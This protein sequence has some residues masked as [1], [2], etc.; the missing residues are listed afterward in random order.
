MIHFSLQKTKRTLLTRV[1]LFGL[2]F[3]HDDNNE[4]FRGLKSMEG[5]QRQNEKSERTLRE[6]E[7]QR[8]KERER[9]KEGERERERRER[10][11]NKSNDEVAAMVETAAGKCE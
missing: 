9:E 4:R 8:P 11:G 10:G 5:R 1:F 6:T 2:K 7:K 3:P